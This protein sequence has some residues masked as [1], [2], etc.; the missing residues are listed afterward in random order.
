MSDNVDVSEYMAGGID[1]SLPD[2]PMPE[3][4]KEEKKIVND[5]VETAF[6]F[7]FIGSGQG[8]G[9]IAET[10]H[11]L[12]YRKVCAI[13]TA[14]QDLNTIKLDNKL[15]I[16]DG[17]AGKDPDV[18]GEVFA[19]KK[20][21]VVDFMRYSFGDDFDRIFVCVGAGG[22]T[23][24]GTLE[25]LV[26]SA[27]E[28]QETLGVKNNKVGAIVALPKNSE[29]KRVN[30]NSFKTLDTAY[31]LV[32][33]GAVS[34]LI[35]VDNEKISKLYPG[36]VVSSFWQ[37]ANRSMAGLFHLFNLTAAKDSTYSAFDS[38]D[39]GS[40][41][42][43]GLMVFGASP[44]KDWKDPI[45]ISRSVRD[46][47]KGN[48]LSGGIDLST[49]SCA[50][51]VIVGGKEVLDNVPQSNLDQAYAQISRILKPNSTVHRGIYSGDKEGMTVYSCIGG[52]GKPEEK[53]E[54]LAKLGDL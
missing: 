53:L 6:K 29:G 46:N 38:Q 40:I 51:V 43:S 11:G 16:G 34:P 32:E 27:L 41:L 31:K 1:I 39:Y 15:C 20:E 36:L 2:I 47:L 18:A 21:D 22:G 5:E 10:F 44:V 50:G 19:S 54:E 12:G 3:P 17:G 23:G 9:R 26:E 49:G 8:G 13:N 52:L 33:S 45:S 37:T 14:K 4:V 28:V 30:A 7:C 25:P 42:D 24:A 35:I 48:I